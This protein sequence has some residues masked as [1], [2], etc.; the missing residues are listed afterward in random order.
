MA[1]RLIVSLRAPIARRAADRH[2]GTRR[3][4]FD[5]RG[6]GDDGGGSDQHPLAADLGDEA[7]PAGAQVPV[8]AAGHVGAEQERCHGHQARGGGALT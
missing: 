7:P 4:G 3:S 5:G 1:S 6:E 8:E 2:V